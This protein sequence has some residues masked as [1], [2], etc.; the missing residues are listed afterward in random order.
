MAAPLKRAKKAGDAQP[1]STARTADYRAGSYI[2]AT[3]SREKSPNLLFGTGSSSMRWVADLEAE[4]LSM[5]SLPRRNNRSW[6]LIRSRPPQH[7]VWTKY[8]GPA[9]LPVAIL[10]TCC[11]HDSLDSDVRGL[12]LL[13]LS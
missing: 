10:A 11:L 3:I 8:R 2:F 7:E 6:W 4:T 1:T 12:L 13:L 9:A 5:D